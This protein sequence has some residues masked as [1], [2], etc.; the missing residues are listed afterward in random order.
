VATSAALER[1]RAVIDQI[2]VRF[3]D[4]AGVAPNIASV[5]MCHPISELEA[6]ATQGHTRQ[7]NRRAPRGRRDGA[8]KAGT[9]L[10]ESQKAAAACESEFVP[11]AV[12]STGNAVISRAI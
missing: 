4:A 11:F 12:P 7:A 10:A 1:D 2:A 9:Y 3:T 5:V 6:G 8:R